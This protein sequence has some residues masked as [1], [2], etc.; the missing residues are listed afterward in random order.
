MFPFTVLPAYN[1]PVY[2]SERPLPDATQ[3][4]V[5]GCSLGFCRGRHH[6]RQLQRACKAQRSSNSACGFP[7]LG[8]PTGFIV[9]PTSGHGFR[10][11]FETKHATFS[12]NDLIGE[13]PRPAPRYLVPS[14]EEVANSLIDVL[15]DAA[16]HRPT[17]PVTEV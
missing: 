2:A 9:T 5:R 14:G 3:D 11:T 7:A 13:P 10:K 16:I 6:R 8:S 17:R 15:V 4:S 1:L 12:V